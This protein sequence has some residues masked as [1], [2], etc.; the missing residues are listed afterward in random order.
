MRGCRFG[1]S[2]WNSFK[3]PSNV[4]QILKT[5]VY[6]N[7]NTNVDQQ[8]L[9]IILEP[10]YDEGA[11]EVFLAV[12]GGEAGPTPESVLSEIGHGV[13]VSIEPTFNSRRCH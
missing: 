10:S 1:T 7:N 13:K 5:Q 8:L 2:F 11:R 9:D 4:E 3:Q 12:F 6:K